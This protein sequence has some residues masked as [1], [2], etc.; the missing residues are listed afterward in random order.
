[1]TKQ[2]KC[3]CESKKTNKKTVKKVEKKITFLMKLK[4]FFGLA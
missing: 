2:V 4:K 1:M 3:K